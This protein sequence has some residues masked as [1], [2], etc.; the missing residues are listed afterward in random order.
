M[1]ESRV[2]GMRDS[3]NAEVS[4]L[5]GTDRDARAY[6]VR[7]AELRNR[8]LVAEDVRRQRNSA[9]GVPTALRVSARV[10]RSEA[11]TEAA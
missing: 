3:L 11:A 8:T 5:N 10:Q 4:T 1:L 2:R 6:A 7:Y 9:R